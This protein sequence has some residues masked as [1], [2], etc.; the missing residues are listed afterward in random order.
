MLL[1]HVANPKAKNTP[2][3]GY[4]QHPEA[5][6]RGQGCKDSS[7]AHTERKAPFFISLSSSLDNDHSVLHLLPRP[8]AG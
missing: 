1:S 4:H 5:H 6:C 2:V 3:A 7:F 8:Q